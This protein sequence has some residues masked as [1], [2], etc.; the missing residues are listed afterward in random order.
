MI[1]VMMVVNDNKVEG[2]IMMMIMIK[3][4]VFEGDNKGDWAR[5]LYKH[6]IAFGQIQVSVS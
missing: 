1:I 6:V 2:F 3:G 5:A 4:V